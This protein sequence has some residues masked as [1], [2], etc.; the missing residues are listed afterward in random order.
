MRY[1]PSIKEKLEHTL[2]T[3][4]RQNQGGTPGL[5]RETIIADAVTQGYISMISFMDILI[6]DEQFMT[7]LQTLPEKETLFVLRDTLNKT[8]ITSSIKAAE[9]HVKELRAVKDPAERIDVYNSYSGWLQ[10][11]AWGESTLFA[12]ID[13]RYSQL[14]EETYDGKQL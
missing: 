3:F 10:G 4:I 7:K 13:E 1:L 8:V 12:I 9:L 14:D 2:E 5:S 11:T 6:G